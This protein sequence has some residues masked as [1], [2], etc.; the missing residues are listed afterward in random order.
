MLIIWQK[1]LDN[2]AGV[3]GATFMDLYKSFDSSSQQLLIAKLEAYGF[4]SKSLNLIYSYLNHCHRVE[5]IYS[6]WL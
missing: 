5:S 1:C 2:N 6:A 3:V 4:G